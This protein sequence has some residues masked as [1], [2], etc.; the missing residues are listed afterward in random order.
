MI[1]DTLTTFSSAQA[2][3]ST[4]ASTDYMDLTPLGN[5][6]NTNSY[7]DLGQGEPLFLL[8]DVTT[9]F[10]ASTA[11]TLSVAVQAS[12]T[13]TFTSTNT[14]LTSP[15]FTSAQLAS[16][17]FYWA[18]QLPPSDQWL[19]YVRLYYT[20]TTGPFTAGVV[21]A[22]IIKD[23]ARPVAYKTGFKIS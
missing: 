22:G 2:I 14:V 13:S 17:D 10:A 7:R 23:L 20:V 16:T 4:V 9:A 1:L 18:Q 12:S 21:K 8:M 6:L 11:A 3:T 19:P 15:T 5:G